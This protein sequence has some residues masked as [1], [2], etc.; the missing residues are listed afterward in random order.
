MDTTGHKN[1]SAI[2]VH[3]LRPAL[4]NGN[5][6]K[7]MQTGAFYLGNWLTDVSQC[8]D[9]IAY[10]NALGKIDGFDEFI[11][12]IFARMHFDAPAWMPA[13]L[14]DITHPLAELRDALAKAEADFHTHVKTTLEAGSN[15]DLA[16]G[17]K[18][19][20]RYIGHFA[21]VGDAPDMMASD[22]FEKLFNERF[23]QY[24]P[25][26]HLDRPEV[27]PIGYDCEKAH[28]PLNQRTR[29]DGKG[30]LY[31][32]LR[33]D[34]ELAAGLLSY[35]DSGSST[36]KAHQSWASAT[37]H[38]TRSKFMGRDGK[39][40][41]VDDKSYEWNYHLAMLGHALHAVEDFFAHS[42]FV[43]HASSTFPRSYRLFQSYQESDVLVRRLKQWEQ[44][45]VEHPDSWHKL[46]DDTHV[47]TGYFDFQD[48]LVSVSHLIDHL[49]KRPNE[50][51]GRKIDNA[52]EYDYLKLLTDTLD[53]VSDFDKVWPDPKNNPK[54]RGYDDREGNLAVKL[55]RERG[56]M[57]LETLEG[58]SRINKVVDYMV[59]H[60][61]EDLPQPVKDS[62]ADCVKLL[63]AAAVGVSIYWSLKSIHELLTAP[64]TW[65]TRY[66]PTSVIRA[67][68]LLDLVEPYLK[69]LILDCIGAKRIGCHSLI[70]KDSG[71]EMLSKA[72]TECARAVHWYVVKTMTR[73]HRRPRV[74][75]AK[76]SAHDKNRNHVY[77]VE[78]ID[79]LELC[80]YFL[81]HPFATIVSQEVTREVSATIVHVTG[82]KLKSGMSSDSLASLA[83]Q[84][85]PT[86]MPV[87]GG[88]HELTW[89]TIADANFPTHNMSHQRRMQT[90][91]RV[92]RAQG[93]GLLVSDGVN[94]AFKPGLRIKIP[95]QK[96]RIKVLEPSGTSKLWWYPVI[97]GESGYKSVAAWFDGTGGLAPGAPHHAHRPFPIDKSEGDAFYHRVLASQNA[98]R[99]AYEGSELKELY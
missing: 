75:A 23:T 4:E 92:L 97:V 24:F 38:G 37:F 52:L 45:V 47:V 36:A 31:T 43:E 25:H 15:G 89:E 70:A 88:P 84:Y 80:E 49:L 53:L 2:G 64:L 33:S 94:L 8:I 40:H 77:L 86:F 30:D 74:D 26:E 66:V 48:T 68:R 19:A 95:Y 13:I 58:Q 18:N 5:P 34:I 99:R 7:K 46:P 82:G 21:F 65:L 29:T 44:S 22:I 14:D 10:R 3:L 72:S 35:L 20:F 93:T 11:K 98:L 17:F 60:P 41:P 16:S 50:K 42:T 9:P 6:G 12:N 87:P 81:C 83:E 79:W 76:S 55:L 69:S 57:G 71:P 56:G 63:G 61:L 27:S 96:T 32:Y 91:N 28:G 90:V 59:T 39:L 67:L 62:F 85:R 78:P 73:H 51:V 1:L 54:T